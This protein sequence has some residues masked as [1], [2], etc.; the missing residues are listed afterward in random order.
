[1]FGG[2]RTTAAAAIER[3][4]GAGANAS[5]NQPIIQCSG[6]RGHDLARDIV[7]DDGSQSDGVRAVSHPDLRANPG[8][9]QIYVKIKSHT[10]DDS[11]YRNEYHIFTI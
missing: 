1:M 6:S 11:W 8:A 5:I 3:E 4:Q 2:A 7:L 9:N 10:Y